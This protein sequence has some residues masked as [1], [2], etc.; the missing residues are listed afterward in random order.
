MKALTQGADERGRIGRGLVHFPIA[1]DQ[2]CAQGFPL[3]LLSMRNRD[4]FERSGSAARPGS[5][6]P[7]SNS[8][9][10]PPPVEMNDMLSDTPA[11]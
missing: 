9:A 5:V 7:S 4:Q 10:A 8:R 6:F 1:D 11:R 3:A 2:A